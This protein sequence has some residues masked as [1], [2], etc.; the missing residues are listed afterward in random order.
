MDKSVVG[1]KNIEEAIFKLTKFSANEATKLCIG[2]KDFYHQLFMKYMDGN[3]NTPSEAVKGQTYTP[4][5]SAHPK[6]NDEFYRH[7]IETTGYKLKA[8]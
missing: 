3:L 2:W 8:Y 5:N 1:L 7:V 4:I 6:Y